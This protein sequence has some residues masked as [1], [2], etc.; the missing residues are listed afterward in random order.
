MK[1]RIQWD[2]PGFDQFECEHLHQIGQTISDAL[3]QFVT[4][5]IP[6]QNSTNDQWNEVRFELWL[7]TGR[8]IVFA[9]MRP[10]SERIDVS[11]VMVICH[12]LC[13]ILDSPGLVTESEY[14][15]LHGAM[16]RKIA[17]VIRDVASTTLPFEF[18]I[19]DF[20]ES[21]VVGI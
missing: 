12:E 10:Y 19:Y 14:E 3:N 8:I 2:T 18:G 16:A 21:E 15:Q 13:D 5:C 4:F 9:A 17:D 1:N 20:G 6:Q 11:G 7:D